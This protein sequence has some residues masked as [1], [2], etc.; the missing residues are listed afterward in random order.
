MRDG[1][2]AVAHHRRGQGRR[3][4]SPATPTAGSLVGCGAL[5]EE[6]VRVEEIVELKR[7]FATAEVRE[8]DRSV[9]MAR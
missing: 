5:P 6:L 4:R 8:G 7:D 1:L 9:A 2:A 3:A